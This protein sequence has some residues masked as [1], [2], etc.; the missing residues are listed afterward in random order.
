MYSCYPLVVVSCHPPK[1]EATFQDFR[2]LV[3]H[4]TDIDAVAEH[5]KHVP[6]LRIGGFRKHIASF[7]NFLFEP[8]PCFSPVTLEHWHIGRQAGCERT[9]DP[10]QCSITML[11]F[12]EHIPKSEIKWETFALQDLRL[13]SLRTLSSP[14]HLLRW[15]NSHTCLWNI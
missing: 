11:L 3:R 1:N 14:S 10:S 13:S 6:E 9:T 2:D 12:K 5:L 15:P 4:H 7:K 8:R